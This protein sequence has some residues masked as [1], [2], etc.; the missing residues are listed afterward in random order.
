[1]NPLIRAFR[2]GFVKRPTFDFP[3]VKGKTIEELVVYDDPQN[4]R[5]VLMRFA[6][7]TMLSVVMETATAV[8]GRLYRKDGG[9]MQ[10]LRTRGDTLE[11]TG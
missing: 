6:D 5:E 1:M 2:G 4:G 10:L 3:E 11:P 7:E 9:I 8:A